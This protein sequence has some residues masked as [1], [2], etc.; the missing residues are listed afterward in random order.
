MY[1]LKY[2]V[3]T[4]L[5]FYVNVSYCLK[6]RVWYF[7]RKCFPVKICVCASVWMK[8]I[9]QGNSAHTGSSQML[10]P[11]FLIHSRGCPSPHR[12]VSDQNNGSVTAS[13]SWSRVEN[14]DLQP[15]SFKK[16]PLKSQSTKPCMSVDWS[17]AP[18]PRVSLPKPPGYLGWTRKECHF[19]QT[20]WCLMSRILDVRSADKDFSPLSCDAALPFAFK[21]IY[22]VQFPISNLPLHHQCV[23]LL[24]I[25]IMKE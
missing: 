5:I 21:V 1:K 18:W 6:F 4:L 20:I 16:A 10:P 12:W 11:C 13:M 25:V 19:F 15:Q 24:N 9:L 22:S 2:P 14:G 8:I 17:P 3:C 23:A 7:Y